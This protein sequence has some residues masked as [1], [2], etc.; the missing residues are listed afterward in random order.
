M[1]KKD[2]HFAIART[3]T[4][5]SMSQVRSPSRPTTK[6][7]VDTFAYYLLHETQESADKFL[8][9]YSFETHKDYEKRIQIINGF[10]QYLK[11]HHITLFE[12]VHMHETISSAKI[13][14]ELSEPIKHLDHFNDINLVNKCL[15]EKGW[16]FEI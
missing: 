15:Y 10:S 3:N 16:L 2:L 11:R 9:S 12:P 6:N 1:I 14:A 13:M 4:M 5:F 7:L 8:A